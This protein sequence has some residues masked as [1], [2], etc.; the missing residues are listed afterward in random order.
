MALCQWLVSIPSPNTASPGLDVMVTDRAGMRAST[1]AKLNGHQ[2][3]PRTCWI[4]LLLIPPSTLRIS[5]YLLS[6]EPF[7]FLL[8]QIS[9]WLVPLEAALAAANSSTTA[10][11]SN[12]QD[13]MSKSGGVVSD[14]RT[15]DGSSPHTSHLK[16]KEFTVFYRTQQ[17]LPDE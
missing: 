7:S 9:D 13:H 16:S 1:L 17:L 3:V 2:Q 11:S 4:N 5:L 10:S 14:S 6:H 12:S 8:L 15:V